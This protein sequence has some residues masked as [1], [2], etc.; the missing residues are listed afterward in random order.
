M[1]C[2]VLYFDGRSINIKHIM[3]DFELKQFLHFVNKFDRF[4]AIKYWLNDQSLTNTFI[5]ANDTVIIRGS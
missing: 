3:D 2:H 4:D 1:R 5:L